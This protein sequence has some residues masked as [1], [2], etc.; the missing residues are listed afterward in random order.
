M[1]VDDALKILKKAWLAA[2]RTPL[3]ETPSGKHRG[4]IVTCPAC[5]LPILMTRPGSVEHLD[6]HRALAA[7]Q[8]LR[9]WREMAPLTHWLPIPM[10]A[11]AAS[12]VV[13]GGADD[14]KAARPL[15][16]H[17]AARV[18]AQEEWATM[19]ALAPL[20][21]SRGARG[22]VGKAVRFVREQAY[23]LRLAGVRLYSVHWSVPFC[24]IH[25]DDWHEIH[26]L[27]RSD[28]FEEVA[29]ALYRERANVFLRD[30]TARPDGI[31][32]H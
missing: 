6:H 28:D 18:S 25:E 21:L 27:T 2:P 19:S 22:Q 5:R 1:M 3:G 26:A 30:V 32:A 16:P 7:E 31:L 29:R 15:T 20:A 9:F 8:P 12:K 14:A 11:S 24:I 23:L 4:A 13:V 10:R 17:E